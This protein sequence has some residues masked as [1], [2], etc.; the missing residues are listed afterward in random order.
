MI[1]ES[2][3]QPYRLLIVDDVPTVRE[4]LRYLL[5]DEARFSV[6]GE[7]NDGLEALQRS[8]ELF[9]DLVI[10]DIE[11]PRLDGYNVTRLL[12]ARPKPP[13]VILLSVHGDAQSR[14]RGA[15][16]GSDGFIEKGAAWPELLALMKQVLDAS[17]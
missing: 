6:V 16:A 10:L 2:V 5:Q 15:E 1:D 8:A 13:C 14:Q 11:L 3:E 9:P 12:K 7:A 17:R 4:A